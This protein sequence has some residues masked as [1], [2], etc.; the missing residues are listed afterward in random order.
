M[1]NFYLTTAVC[2]A[3]VLLFSK[4][5]YAY[6][7]PGTGSMLLQG[8]IAAVAGGLMVIRSYWGK[9][10]NLLAPGKNAAKK[11]SA[12]GAEAKTLLK[13]LWGWIGWIWM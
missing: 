10:K 6:L 12:D 9:W 1:K 11:S 5:A 2:A 7:D 8:L 4:R 3:L 13:K